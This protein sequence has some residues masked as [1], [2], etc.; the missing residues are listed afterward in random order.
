MK[1]QL[2]SILALLISV[3]PIFSK[4][5]D[6]DYIFFENSLMEGNWYYSFVNYE[7]PSWIMNINGHLP[8]CED[9][10]SSAG[11]SLVLNYITNSEKGWN[12]KLHY[13]ETRGIEQ[14]RKPEILSI[15]MKIASGER[16]AA[17]PVLT[18]I[19]NK[20]NKSK[21]VALNEYADMSAVGKW[22]TVTIPVSAF[23]ITTSTGKDMIGKAAVLE[24]GSAAP[25]EKEMKIYLDDIE[26]L[27]LQTPQ[28]KVEI[29]HLSEVK[30]YERHFDLK[31]DFQDNDAVKYYRIYRSEDGQNFQ[32]VAISRPWMDRYTDFT[33]RTDMTAYYRITAVDY[34]LNESAPSRIL[35]ATTY[36]MT[37][38]Q[39]LDMVQEANFRFYWEGAEPCS[40]LSREDIPGRTD[41]IAAGASGFGMMAIL[42]GIHKG[43]ITREQGVERFLRITAFLE[44]AKKYHGVYPHFMDGTTGET[45]PWFGRR[46]NGGD[47]VETAFMFQGLLSAHQYF[48][49]NNA[50]EKL[51][52][53]RIDKMWNEI[54]W[55]WYKRTEDSPYIYWHWSPDQEWVINHKL[56]G[57]N[58]TMIVYLMA[59]MSP[60]HGVSPEMYYSGWASQEDVAA[61]YR[62]AWTT[63]HDGERYTNGNTYFGKKLDVAASNGGPLFF[64]HYSY[65]GFDPHALTDR[66]TN[67]FENNKTIAQ[68][69]HRY[70]MENPK[71]Y[72]GYGYDCWGLTASDHMWNYCASEP[73]EHIDDGT[74]APTGALASFPYTPV[75]SMAALKNYYRNYGSFLWG[76]YGFRD[77][78]NL[79]ANWVSPIFMGL[80]QGPVTVMI[81]NWRSGFVWNLFMSHPDVKKGLKKLNSIR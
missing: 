5:R 7:D 67:Y 16:A 75:E 56:I 53:K 62:S 42:T 68:I 52:R 48:D 64:I 12:V 55:D 31:W 65:T 36:P 24:F 81:E 14:F 57:W 33:G 26:F 37:D 1:R 25:C 76:E 61:E 74:V 45:V 40:G 38:E 58:E 2:I 17:L 11:N 47:L 43:F 8:V 20:D 63:V 72:A 19:D 51:I 35:S 6:F 41:M 71:K 9:E 50:D 30:A 10:F 28:G 66:Y 60:K 73:M 32:P 22:Q 59:I 46:D 18:I 78:F 77:A 27:P 23:G 79:T 54:E 4:E 34:A 44:K 13:A 49:G 21:T 15:R 29:P 3:A 70:C 80:N 69:N 39:L